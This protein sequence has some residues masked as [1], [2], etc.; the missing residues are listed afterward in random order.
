MLSASRERA[1]EIDGSSSA[2]LRLPRPPH[3]VAPR[4][5]TPH[6]ADRD[7]ASWDDGGEPAESEREEPVEPDHPA[8]RADPRTAGH[9]GLRRRDVHAAGPHPQLLHHRPHRP[10]QVDARRPHAAD[11]RCPGGA[12]LPRAVPRPHGHRAR[13]RHHHQGAERAPALVRRGPRRR[14]ARPRPAP[15][16]H[17]GPRRLHLRGQ[18]LAGRVRGRDPAGRR[19]AG[20]RGADPGQPLPGHGARPRDHPGAQQDRPPGRRARA[21]RRGARAPHRLRARRRAAHLGQDR[22]RRG[23]RAR[24]GRA[25]R[26]RPGG[27]RRRPSPGD[28]LRLGLRHLPRRRH[29]HP[30]RRRPDHPARAHP[31]DV[32]ERGAR[33]ARGRDHLAGPEALPGPRRRRGR[34]PHDRREGRPAVPRRRHRDVGAQGR[35]RAARRLPRPAA[36]GLLRALSD[37]RVGLPAAA[38]RARPPAAQRRGAVLRA[39][40]LGGARL[41]LPLRLPRPA[42]PRDHARPPGARVRARPDLH[43]AQH[44]LP[45]RARRRR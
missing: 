9:E 34:L 37:R 44:R 17:P 6:I 38:R 1:G 18:P 19:R 24:R 4:L 41:R 36:D 45:R 20:H 2:A 33:A 16:R 30:R 35:H 8:V 29:L 26:A 14:D 11:D 3:A 21:L 22:R 13:A 31:H 23:G 32:D 28:D 39:R 25:P 42:A 27:R 40:D 15:H 10:R 43:G 12:C 5:A 7:R